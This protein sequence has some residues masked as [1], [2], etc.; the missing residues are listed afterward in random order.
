M[1]EETAM[2]VGYGT[3][4]DGRVA[5]VTMTRARY[6][7]ALSAQMMAELDQAFDR[8]IADAE[9]RV[10]VLRGDGPAF[11]AG[12]DL[13]SPDV[14]GLRGQWANDG[15]GQR[16]NRSFALDLE[17]LL[18]WRDLPK[19]TIAAVH[20]HCIFAGWML[21]SCTDVLFAA[22]D[23]QFLGTHFQYFTVPWD[24]GARKAKALLFENRFLTGEQA[25]ELGF[26]HRAVPAAELDT[27]VFAYAERVAE[28]EPFPLRMMKRA[29]NDMQDIQ[30]FRSH[31]IS[32]HMAFMLGASDRATGQAPQGKEHSIVAR[33]KATADSP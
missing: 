3:R 16:Y 22:T 19:P 11:S 29:I 1:S 32:S 4:N 31:I 9:V 27:E 5:V 24:V 25:M 12:H 6:R 30:G 2:R 15:A 20:G 8:A 17:H 18:K 26:V 13:G 23:A 7:N 10:I 28:S 21:A 33:A 14:E